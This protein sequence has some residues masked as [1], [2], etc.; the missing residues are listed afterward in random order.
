MLQASWLAAFG[1]ALVAGERERA[2]RFI[3]P[4]GAKT[5]KPFPR[6]LMRSLCRVNHVQGL[7]TLARR[8]NRNRS[9]QRHR[10]S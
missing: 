7:R 5:T 4:D 2:Q 10:S 1:S 6:P 9:F 8:E 3:R